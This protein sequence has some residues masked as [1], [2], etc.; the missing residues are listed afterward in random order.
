MNPFFEYK[1]AT[2]HAE[3]VPVRDIAEA[4]GT[5]CYIYSHGALRDDFNAF[6]DA[7]AGLDPLICYSVKANSNIAVLRIFS[8]LGAGF[9]IV[10]GGELFRVKAA[11]GD[12][13]KAV[14]SGVG[15]TAREMRDAIEAGILFFNVESRD[16]LIALDGVA[17]EMGTRARVAIRVNPDIDPKTHP[18][19]STGLKQSKF[20]IEYN[21]ALE[22]YREAATL[23]GIEVVGVDAHIGSQIFELDPFTESVRRLV[24]LSDTLVSEGH[25]IRYIDIG[26]GLGIRYNEDDTPPHPSRYAEV[27]AKELRGKPYRIVL[28]PGRFLTGNSGI[29][30]TRVLYNKQGEEK[31]FVIIDAGFNDLLRPAFYNAFHNIKPVDESTTAHEPVDVVGPVCET[32]DVLG[33]DVS[34]P[35]LGSG[36][37]L[38]VFSAGAYG[39]VM[40]SN[41]NSRLRPAEVLVHGGE[42]DVIRERDDTPGL[43]RGESIPRFLD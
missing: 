15:K 23:E 2:L 38:A 21:T 20:G 24:A 30:A 26:G 31:K 5:P 29:L 9:D 18:Y 32:V 8:S 11:G 33:R 43:I 19:I 37:L 7:F 36:E 40:S 6:R 41:Y 42:Y 3:D 39:F 16:E 10:S 14:F 1:N 28:E 12:T 27:V 34:L 17:R 35:V 13:S 25:D 4:V 22:V